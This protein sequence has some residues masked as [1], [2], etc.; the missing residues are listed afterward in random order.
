[1]G[2]AVSVNKC[3]KQCNDLFC[4]EETNSIEQMIQSNPQINQENENPIFKNDNSNY[5]KK[6]TNLIKADNEQNNINNS[7]IKIEENKENKENHE[8]D[9]KKI[10]SPSFKDNNIHKDIVLNNNP[11]ENFTFKYV[12]QANLKNSNTVKEAIEIKNN[13]KSNLKPIT[14]SIIKPKVKNKIMKLKDKNG[15]VISIFDFEHTN[16]EKNKHKTKVQFNIKKESEIKT[17]FE[18]EKNPKNVD[19]KANNNNGENGKRIK[20]SPLKNDNSLSDSVVI[21][22]NSSNMLSYIL[23]TINVSQE[24]SRSVLLKS[25]QFQ[26]EFPKFSLKNRLDND[27]IK[28]NFLLKKMKFKYKGDK[29]PEG[30]KYGFGIILYEDSS[31]L[32]GHFFDSKLNGIVKFYNCGLDNSTYIGEYKNNI[33]AGYGIYSRQGLKLEGMNWNKNYINNIGIAIW[34]NGEIYE[35]EFKNNLKEGI[36]TY[37]WEDGAIYIGNF[38]NNLFLRN[39][40]S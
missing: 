11:D 30:K 24:S 25:N 9:N 5:D 8:N 35:G 18:E 21:K 1:M 4:P 19:N 26:S 16:I 32:E 28:G 2:S 40:F 7:L 6:I 12:K 39:R 33:P 17:N 36:G 37:R 13:I 22:S 27:F 34:D 15:N 10:N 29:D 20:I 38:K 23:E 14:Q 3:Y 31:K